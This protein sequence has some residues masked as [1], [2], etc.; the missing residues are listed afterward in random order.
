MD[1][2]FISLIDLL[3]F[4]VNNLDLLPLDFI[5]AIHNIG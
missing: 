5:L 3:K 2:V 1:Y 4:S